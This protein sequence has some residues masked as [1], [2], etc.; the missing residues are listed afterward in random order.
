MKQIMLNGITEIPRGQHEKRKVDRY[1]IYVARDTAFRFT[2]KDDAAKFLGELRKFYMFKVIEINNAYSKAFAMWRKTWF[3]FAGNKK[4][5]R[6]YRQHDRR[7]RQLMLE[8]FPFQLDFIMHKEKP[9]HMVHQ[10]ISLCISYI[11]ETYQLMREVYQDRK[12]QMELHTIDME[13]EAIFRIRHSFENFEKERAEKTTP[14]EA[15]Y[16]QLQIA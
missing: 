5:S 14:K 11:E 7:C 1:S 8:D 6:D 2:S 13:L 15:A 16:I 12:L 9:A 4:K 3:L 10:K